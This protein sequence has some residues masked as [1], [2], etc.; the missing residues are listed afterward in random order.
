MMSDSKRMTRRSFIKGSGAIAGG[1]TILPSSVI[2]G[3]GHK[4]PSDKLNIAVIGIG[5]KGNENLSNVSAAE[6][7][8][9]LCDVDWRY[10][11]KVFDAHPKAKRYWDFRKMYDEMDKSIDAAIIAT[12]DHTHC[13]A[14]TTGMIRGKHVY[15]QKP[16]THTVYESRLLTKLAAKHKVATQMGNEGASEEGVN[17]VVEWIQNGEIG[18]IKKVEAFTDRPIWPQG[19]SRP[20]KTE[21]IPDTLNWDLFIGPAPMRPYNS[22]YTP[23]NW[24]GWWDFGTGALGV[25]KFKAP[26]SHQGAGKL[27][28]Y[29]DGVGAK[30]R[31]S[32][33]YLPGKRKRW[34]NELPR[35]GSD[36]VRRRT[37]AH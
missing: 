37:A 19:L 5:G 21:K 27:Y 9:A 28:A 17:L 2:S 22:I 30:R 35:S 32:E 36:L 29:I 26:V 11:K 13:I 10:A 14:A 4:A 7:I 33:A 18:E 20:A 12:P 1:F 34:K 24:R 8:V 16:L 31:D 15:V 23:W 25:Q 3:L 6:N